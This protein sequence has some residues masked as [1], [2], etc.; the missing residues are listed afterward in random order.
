M[1]ITGVLRGVFGVSRHRMLVALLEGESTPHQIAEPARGQAKR[2]ITQLTEA[3]VGHRMTDHVRFLIRNFLRH[4]ACLE[5]EL[6][7][8]DTEIVRRMGMPSFQNVYALM[9]T[10]PGGSELSA[11]AI[12][13]ETGTD[14]ASFPTAERM[15]S[16]AGLCQGNRESAG[17]RKGSQ[18]THGNKYLRTAPVQCAWSASRKQGSVFE[19]RFRLL[20]KRLVD[21]LP[22][23]AGKST[24]DSPSQ[25]SIIRPPESSLFSILISPWP[26]WSA[27]LFPE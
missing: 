16:W 3:L 1:K 15:A 24:G 21:I 26:A 20:V 7:E 2:K 4:L 18:T 10:L 23:A 13:A 22:S 19:T 12:L 25:A 9:Q 8:L 5:E 11:A 6:E 17:I 27:S 14:V